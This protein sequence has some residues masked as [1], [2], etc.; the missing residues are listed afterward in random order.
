[1]TREKRNDLKGNFC[2][3]VNFGMKLNIK[4]DLKVD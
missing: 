4:V 3:K 2:L 1:M